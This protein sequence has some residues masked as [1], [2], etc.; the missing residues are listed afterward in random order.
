M[1]L[2]LSDQLDVPLRDRNQL[3][4]AAG[5]APAYSEQPLEAPEMAPVRDALERILAGHE[6]YPAVVVDRWWNLQAANA[7][8][9]L[10]TSLAAPHLLEPPVNALRVTLHPEGIAPHI[11][12]LPEWRAHL[13]ERLRRQVAVT[14]DDRLA[15]LYAELAEYP[16]GEAAL[17][18]H[19]PSIAVPLRIGIGGEEL[20]FLSTIAT[21]GTA[22]DITL[23]ELAIEA[24]LPADAATAQTL[25]SALS[26]SRAGSPSVSNRTA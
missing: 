7:P 6:P 24:F 23:A 5:F 20:A 1:V 8:I 13:L 10:F 17:A 21:F 22:V 11:R 16:G 25:T 14:G 15:A 26:A 18:A 4:L 3:L 2:H 12:N 9:A 19:E